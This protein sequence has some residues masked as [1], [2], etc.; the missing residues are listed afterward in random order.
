MFLHKSQIP[1]QTWIQ[2]IYTITANGEN[3]MQIG[4]TMY[5]KSHSTLKGDASKKEF[6]SS[7]WKYLWLYMPVPPRF[8]V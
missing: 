2:I 1:L 8:S 6:I 7:H 4:E 5:L 3:Q